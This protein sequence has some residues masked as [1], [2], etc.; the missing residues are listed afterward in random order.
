MVTFPVL[1]FT[2]FAFFNLFDLLECLVMS[3][4]SMPLM[5]GSCPNDDD[6]VQIFNLSISV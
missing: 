2:W 1:P 3:L 4:A 6:S 5:V